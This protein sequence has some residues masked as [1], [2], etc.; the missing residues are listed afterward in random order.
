[1]TEDITL[2]RER[3]YTDFFSLLYMSH[4]ASSWLNQTKAY[5]AA[6]LHTWNVQEPVP[7]RKRW[8][9]AWKM[10]PDAENRRTD[11]QTRGVSV[12]V[13]VFT[14]RRSFKSTAKWTPLLEITPKEEERIRNL[15]RILL[16][17]ANMPFSTKLKSPSA[18]NHCDFYFIIHCDHPWW[19]RYDCSTMNPLQTI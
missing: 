3:G 8:V 17:T 4:T 6:R 18:S 5:V 1:M 10:E 2:R 12:S 16:H 13:S 7:V 9:Q 19:F 15:R 14:I 11:S